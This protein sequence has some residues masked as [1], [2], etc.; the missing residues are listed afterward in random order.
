MLPRVAA[1]RYSSWAELIFTSVSAATD[2]FT[3]TSA[4]VCLVVCRTPIKDSSSTS[5]PKKPNIGCLG[6]FYNIFKPSYM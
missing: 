1:G 3:A 6:Y 4:A 5:E 2:N